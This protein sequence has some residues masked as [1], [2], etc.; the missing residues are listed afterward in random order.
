MMNRIVWLPEAL[1]DVERLYDFL[2]EKSPSAA[3]RAAKAILSGAK[4]L[5]TAPEAGRPMNDDTRRRELFVAFGA[6]DYVLRYK[7]DAAGTTVVIR[8]WH[9]R[10]TGNDKSTFS[11][12]RHRR[13]QI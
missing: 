8:V 6:G 3:Q 5:E 1:E 9:S 2:A 7:I 12:L 11:H 13:Y 10:R 4:L